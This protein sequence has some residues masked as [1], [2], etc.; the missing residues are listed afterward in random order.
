MDDQPAQPEVTAQPVQFAPLDSPAPAPR[1]DAATLDLLMDVQ[2]RVSVELGRTR[3]P[4]KEVLALQQGSVVELDR[5]AG[6]PVD[7]LVNDRL[8]AHGEVVVIE[9]KFGIRITETISPSK[10]QILE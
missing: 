5:L 8:I 2:L 6:E 4:V 7:V 1:P 10:R 9:D 3:L